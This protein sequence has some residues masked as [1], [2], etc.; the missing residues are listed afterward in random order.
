MWINA[1]WGDALKDLGEAQRRVADTSI[2]A[3]DVLKYK[4]PNI[5]SRKVSYWV[6]KPRELAAKR[7]PSLPLRL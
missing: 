5:S 3:T 7:P 4:L 1:N 2:T 6:G